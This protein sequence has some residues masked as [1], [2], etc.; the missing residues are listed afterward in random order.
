MAVSL[1]PHKFAT[2]VRIIGGMPKIQITKKASDDMAYLIDKA[3]EEISW[4]GTVKMLGE[5]PQSATYVIEEIFVIDQHVSG[6]ETEMNEDGLGKFGH[7]MT[8]KEN[9]MEVLNRLHFWG[10][11]HVNMDTFASSTDIKQMEL[12]KDNDREYF[13]RGIFNK[14]GKAQFSIFLYEL[15]VE[16]H[17]VEWNV[18]IPPPLSKERRDFWDAEMTDKVHKK[19]WGT[20]SFYGGQSAWSRNLEELDKITPVRS[21]R[22]LDYKN[23]QIVKFEN[24]DHNDDR[25]RIRGGIFSAPLTSVSKTAQAVVSATFNEVDEPVDTSLAAYSKV[26]CQGLLSKELGGGVNEDDNISSHRGNFED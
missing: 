16:F 24:I 25:L 6:A 12:F 14:A 20:T 13:I 21:Q 17:D 3:S 1:A 26:E 19:V 15:N 9:G 7:E 11:S 8:Q 18:L 22:A 23:K 10:H 2:T 5:D 4:L